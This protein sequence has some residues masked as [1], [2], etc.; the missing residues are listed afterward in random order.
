MKRIMPALAAIAVLAGCSG[1]PDADA[2][3]ASASATPQK[4]V[5]DPQLKALD[6]A[7]G[8]Q[9]I[10]DQDK[11]HTDQAIKDSGG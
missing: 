1:A 10:L 8:V 4:T 11:A 6:K 7:R 5:F 9:K 3:A 2:P